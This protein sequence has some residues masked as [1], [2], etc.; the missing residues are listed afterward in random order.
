MVRSWNRGF[1]ALLLVLSTT[2]SVSAPAPMSNVESLITGVRAQLPVLASAPG[3]RASF[4]RIARSHP[5]EPSAY[6]DFVIVRSLFEAT[7][8]AGFWNLGWTITNREPVSDTVW[9]QWSELSSPSLTRPTAY[10]ECDELSALHA[11][12]SGRLGVRGVGLLWPTANHTVAVW[13]TRGR[14]G[15]VRLI[16]PTTQIFL[17]SA[18]MLGTTRFDPWRQKTIHEYSRRDVHSSF[19]LRRGL[20][21]FFLRQMLHHGC[22]TDETLQYLRYLRA[23]VFSDER[24]AVE[25]GR[26]ALIRS[27]AV[28][29]PFDRAALAQFAEDMGAPR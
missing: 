2:R 15:P 20:V 19:A 3:P 4:E 5:L 8:D 23:A 17:S 18:D 9:R 26:L 25:M 16:I 14:T 11:Y 27:R 24:R 13:N 1:L 6:S 29:D 10:A 22:A 21:D 7:R 12:L 28:A